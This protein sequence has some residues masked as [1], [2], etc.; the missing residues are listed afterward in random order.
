MDSADIFSLGA[1]EV[2]MLAG[3]LGGALV[4]V[5]PWWERSDAK[6]IRAASEQ[7]IARTA[8]KAA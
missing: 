4:R 6:A 2:L 3:G 7:A 8:G 1:F 5:I